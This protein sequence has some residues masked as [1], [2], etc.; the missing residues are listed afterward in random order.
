M[1]MTGEI[2]CITMINITCARTIG[3]V[4]GMGVV[5]RYCDN[6]SRAWLI[7][8]G[9]RYQYIYDLVV[10]ASSYIAR[11]PWQAEV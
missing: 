2:N 10:I 6:K 4:V 5:S 3:R 1:N 8:F 7:I 9:H 11:C